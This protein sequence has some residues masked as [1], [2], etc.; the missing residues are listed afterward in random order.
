MLNLLTR[1][2]KSSLIGKAIRE[3]GN[4]YCLKSLITN[5]LS[6][7]EISD[8]RFEDGIPTISTSDN[9]SLSAF[10]E[11][12]VIKY[13][14]IKTFIPQTHISVALD[15]VLRYKYPHFEPTKRVSTGLIPRLYFPLYLHPQHYNTIFELPKPTQSD[16]AKHLYV[17]KGDKVLEIGSFISFGTVRMSRIVGSD[18]HILSIE[19]YKRSFDIAEININN[20]KCNNVTHVNCAI[21]DKSRDKEP[22]YFG[23]GTTG[24]SVVKNVIQEADETFLKSKS[25]LDILSEY[26]FDPSF[27]VLTINGA[28]LK[29]L[30]SCRDF[31]QSKDSLRII[32]PGWYKDDQGYIGP[33]IADFLKSAGFNVAMTKGFHVFAFK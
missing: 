23:G 1:I 8:F 25:I 29:T 14:A 24:N 11:N 32:A 4:R 3:E 9:V 2:P 33:R 30:V 31:L 20:N 18:G 6:E 7:E 16:F 21:S 17:S 15:Y 22:F 27:I 19:A 13:N 12:H 5:N 28:E 10:P 26:K